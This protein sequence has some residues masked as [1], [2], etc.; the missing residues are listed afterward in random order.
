MNIEYK[1]GIGCSFQLE[2]FKEDGT[3]TYKGEPFFNTVLDAGLFKWY[4]TSAASLI[5]YVNIGNNSTPPNISQTGLGNRLFSTNTKYSTDLY[6]DSITDN[7]LCL[8][9]T[10]V[11]QF[12]VGTCTGDFT[13]I[14]L[15]NTSNASYFNRQL[16][17][18]VLGE[19]ITVR[20]NANEGL[21]ITA[22]LRIYCDNTVRYCSVGY[23]LDTKGATSGS[24]VITNGT[25]TATVNLT[26]LISNKAQV[27]TNLTPLGTAPKGVW[28][29]L[30]Y[31]NIYSIIYSTGLATNPNLSIQSHTLVGGSAAPTL[32]AYIPFLL[33]ENYPRLSFTF[34]DP[35]L[36]INETRTYVKYMNFSTNGWY[37][38][39]HGSVSIFSAALNILNFVIASKSQTSISIITAATLGNNSYTSKTYYA[40]GVLTNTTTPYSFVG[41]NM[42][43]GGDPNP[44]DFLLYNV[45]VDTPISV[46]NEEEFS[47]EMIVSWGRFTP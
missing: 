39:S 37:I 28:N 18:D 17:K 2:K 1:M 10:R 21:R 25:T 20:V 14:G 41:C 31:S 43:K 13:E 22:R 5:N 40:P 24:V 15:S 3:I 16:L 11:F 36:A 44:G 23:K 8:S 26:D 30:D 7:L 35:V 29:N 27:V 12:G 33:P 38:S 46:T 6:E 42:T 19:I 45:K 34:E 32:E 47:F 4:T 9:L